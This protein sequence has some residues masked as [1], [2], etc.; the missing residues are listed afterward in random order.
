VRVVRVVATRGGRGEATACGGTIPEDLV[1]KSAALI[2]LALVGVLGT[3][4]LLA[5]TERTSDGDTFPMD[6]LL[7]ESTSAFGTVG[8]TLGITPDLS[9]AG[10]VAM[11]ASMFVGRVGIF[12][13]LAVLL[14]GAMKRRP[15]VEYPT[16]SVVVY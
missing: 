4:G 16:E 10:K 12:A 6:V 11:I 3:T 15:R 14:S 13:L 2:V 7:F 8:L 1:R 9:A 5:L